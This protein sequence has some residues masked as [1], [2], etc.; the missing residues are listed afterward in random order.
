MAMIH[1]LAPQHVLLPWK[2]LK[3]R[4]RMKLLI[5]FLFSAILTFCATGRH[6]AA[7]WQLDAA[8]PDSVSVAVLDVATDEWL[9]IANES[10]ENIIWY[11]AAKI[12][13]ESG[14]VD[15]TFSHV[16]NFHSADFVYP[17]HTPYRGVAPVVALARKIAVSAEETE[18]NDPKHARTGRVSI[19]EPATM[20]LLGSGIFGLLAVARKRKK[21]SI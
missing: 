5:V 3:E 8:P 11:A 4:K 14:F 2:V 10:R 16:Y 1:I 9:H 15:D 6:P 13:D 7:A 17:N 18:S 12:R 19:P 21:N 20:L